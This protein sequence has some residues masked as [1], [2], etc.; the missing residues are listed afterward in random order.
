MAAFGPRSAATISCILENSLLLPAGAIFGL[1]WANGALTSYARAAHALEFAVND[2][3]MVFF[4]GLAA[5]EVFEAGE[6]LLVS[7]EKSGQ[8]G[9]LTVALV[10]LW[11]LNSETLFT[12]SLDSPEGQ[13]ILARLTAGAT[14]GSADATPLGALVHY[15]KDADSLAAARARCAALGVPSA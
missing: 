7:Y 3:G 9:R 2:V 15:L 4:F 10:K 6:R 5:K 14:A 11:G 13:D 1:L 8:K 12:A